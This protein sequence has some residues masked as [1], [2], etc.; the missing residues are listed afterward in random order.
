MR[1]KTAVHFRAA[2]LF[3]GLKMR[4]YGLNEPGMNGRINEA[5]HAYRNAPRKQRRHAPTVFSHES[6]IY[7]ESLRTHS[8][9]HGAYWY[10]VEICEHIIP[11]VKTDRPW[12][13]IGYAG[14]CF[15]HAIVFAHCNYHPHVYSYLEGFKDLVLV[16]SWPQQMDAVRRWGTPV[17]LP[18]S[19][20]V[21]YV[22][23]FARPKDR[24][25]CFAGRMEKCTE[26]LAHAPGVDI[27]SG[28]DRDRFLF[29]LARYRSVYAID[30]TAIEAK[31]L[32]CEV[33]PY[34]SRFPDP[35]F[36]QVLDSRDAAQMLQAELDRVDS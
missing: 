36:W 25:T 22:R 6:P 24:G 19:V 14:Q 31:V 34:D 2:F 21:D 26:E 4:H 11:R 35:S 17:F 27:V 15:D 7:R 32:G 10:S 9:D 18:L 23:R 20:D 12:V 5:A 28:L 30:R 33:L 13:T 3:Y 1:L 29:E 8:R 16:C